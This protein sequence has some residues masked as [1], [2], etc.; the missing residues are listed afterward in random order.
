MRYN[1]LGLT[2][3]ETEVYKYIVQFKTVNGFSPT[4]SDIS[5]GL[6]KS[7]TS[8]RYALN[9]LQDKDVI[10]FVSGKCRTIT[11]IKMLQL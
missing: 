6:Y 8:I 10:R 4:I 5:A 3:N 11:I 1:E 2:R 7:R 9:G